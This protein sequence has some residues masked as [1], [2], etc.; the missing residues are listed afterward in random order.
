MPGVIAY[1]VPNR[2]NPSALASGQSFDKV[3]RLDTADGRVL[4]V[5]PTLTTHAYDG[6]APEHVRRLP[7]PFD[8]T[9]SQRLADFFE[10][11]LLAC[12]DVSPAMEL[13]DCHGFGDLMQGTMTATTRHNLY[14]R[15]R[16]EVVIERGTRI[17]PSDLRMGQLAVIGGI[18]AEGT[19]ADHSLIN[20]DGI[21]GLQIL[22]NHGP[23]VVMEHT[24]TLQHYRAIS[25]GRLTIPE[26]EYGMHAAA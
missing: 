19:L 26:S 11:Q 5:P 8:A 7:L 18:D 14:S 4:Q 1:T 23:L 10:N 3:V 6:Y 13:F 17:D 2:S 22:G 12:L 15:R 25:C 21:L 24:A 9:L 16:A 20:L